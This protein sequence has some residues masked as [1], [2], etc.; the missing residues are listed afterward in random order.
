MYF[1]IC[2]KW[3]FASTILIMN[4]V[5]FVKVIQMYDK[6]AENE[7]ELQRNLEFVKRGIH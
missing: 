2:W 3:L 5:F 1:Q 4:I 6:T 7:K